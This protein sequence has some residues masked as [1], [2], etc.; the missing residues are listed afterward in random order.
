MQ[1]PLFVLVR[2]LPQAT[3]TSRPTMVKS[4][5]DLDRLTNIGEAISQAGLPAPKVALF[6]GEPTMDLLV[7]TSDPKQTAAL[8]SAALADRDVWVAPLG[9]KGDLAYVCHMWRHM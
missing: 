4:Q 9:R 2:V 3:W 8:L 6:R 5:P 7:E 1:T